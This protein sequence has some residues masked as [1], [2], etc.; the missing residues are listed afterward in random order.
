M[1]AE[2]DCVLR[3]FSILQ[4]MNCFKLR[5]KLNSCALNKVK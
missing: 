1:M 2:T 5:I 3:H 4:F